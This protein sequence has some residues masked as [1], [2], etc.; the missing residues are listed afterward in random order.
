M[1]RDILYDIARTIA[2][3]LGRRRQ[4]E[5]LGCERERSGSIETLLDGND[6]YA[7]HS[8]VFRKEQRPPFACVAC[9]DSRCPP[10][11]IFAQDPGSCFT[12]RSAG[13]VI[14]DLGSDTLD[15][16]VDV[17]RVKHIL[18]LSHDDCA[19]LRSAIGGG[20]GVP[21]QKIRRLFE[22]YSETTGDGA[23]T[24][25][26]LARAQALK[27]LEDERIRRRFDDGELKVSY[28]VFNDRSGRVSAWELDRNLKSRRSRTRK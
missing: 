8:H 11:L 9:S 4:R 15:I 5:A 16:G 24:P 17:L 13:A 6:F 3:T 19:A 27:L 18:V 12:Y 22:W 10:E 7:N 20:R 25:A 21:Q 23:R 28:G 2:A 26:S 1:A 14:G